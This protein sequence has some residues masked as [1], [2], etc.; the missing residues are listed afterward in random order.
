MYLTIE[1]VAARYQVHENTIRNWV[2]AGSFP[3][4]VRHS[5]RWYRWLLSDLEAFD[6]QMIEQKD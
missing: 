1:Q 3:Q 2:R 6:A 5:R 4:P